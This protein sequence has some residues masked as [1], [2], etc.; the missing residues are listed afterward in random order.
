MRYIAINV[1]GGLAVLAP[2][3]G[4]SALQT[5]AE[6][7]GPP[8]MTTMGTA[9]KADMGAIALPV[10]VA[11]GDCG[12]EQWFSWANETSVRNV[13]KPTIL[14]VRP[15]KDEANGVA[16]I[17]APGGGF[18]GLRYEGEGLVA[19]KELARHGI[20]AFVLKYRVRCT[21]RDEAGLK[22]FLGKVMADSAK[23][24]GDADFPPFDAASAD[25]T[26]AISYL[27]SNASV[28]G[29]DPGK[30]G[31]LGF[32]AGA[33]T[34][35][36]AA[37][38]TGA[39]APN[40]VAPIYPQMNMKLAVPQP[41]PPMFLALASNDSLFGRQGTEVLRDWSAAGGNVEFHLYQGGEHGFGFEKRGTTSDHWFEQFIW[42]LQAQKIMPASARDR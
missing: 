37:E 21:P 4:A 24:L 7:G 13:Q 6:K 27:R 10:K 35:L 16:V 31:F 17:V 28:L 41:P 29:I 38:R 39:D 12:G 26:A 2:Q 20:T 33:I 30:I 25:A 34:A 23:K 5:Q 14:P 22:S 36:K 1:L 32:S 19:A 3:A 8:P 15:P 40:F 9:G 11:S 42:W 18:T